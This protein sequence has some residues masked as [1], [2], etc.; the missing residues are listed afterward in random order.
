MV[1]IAV[2]GSLTVLPA[3]LAWLGDRVEKGGGADHLEDAVERERER[4]SGRGS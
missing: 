2:I 3:L 1:A 4:D